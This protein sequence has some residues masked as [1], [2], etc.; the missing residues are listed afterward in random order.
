MFALGLPGYLSTEEGLAAY[1]EELTGNTDEE[2]MRD[3]AGRVIAVNSVC[4]NLSFREAYEKLRGYGFTEGKAWRLAIRAHR[5]GG[6][7]KD[8]VYLKGYFQ[9]K[10]FAEKNGDLKSLYVGKIGIQHLPLV[11]NLLKEGILKKP[12]YLPVFLR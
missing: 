2:K 12:K 5:G 8:H 4:K 10:K 11:K 6:Y 3:Y 1:F 7:I 9:V